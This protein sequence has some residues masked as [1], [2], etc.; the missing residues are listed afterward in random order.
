MLTASL[1][2][3]EFAEVHS[4][5]QS[6]WR[7]I[8]KHLRR[9][10]VADVPNGLLLGRSLSELWPRSDLLLSQC[11]GYDVIGAYR[12]TLVPL[13]AP[14]FDVAECSGHSYLSHIVVPKG[15]AHRNLLD[16]RGTIVAA[17]G[18]ESH[19]GT[20][21]LKSLVAP[22]CVNGRFFSKTI[23]TGAH[24]E[25]LRL[26]REEKADVAA[27][28]CVTFSILRRY[29]PEA[30][31]GVE[32]IGQTPLAPAPPYVT[33]VARAPSTHERIR[34]ALVGAFEDPNHKDDRSALLIDTLSIVDRETYQP[35]EE[36]KIRAERFGYN[37]LA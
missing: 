29:R 21:T 10:G 9:E 13:A 23:F 27:I 4:A 16:M 19:S 1:P 11:C 3:Y 18:P 37:E 24:V 32:I 26:L 15:S 35:I 28:D 14:V 25:S 33:H 5:M 12:D 6:F 30:V 34:A 2:M 31:A 22:K 36:L 7:G 20:N 17:N 8:A